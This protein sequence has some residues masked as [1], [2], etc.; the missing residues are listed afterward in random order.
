MR[1]IDSSETERTRE[2]VVKYHRK[3][4]YEYNTPFNS[5]KFHPFPG[6]K[7]FYHC[8]RHRP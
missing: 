7:V 4:L 5:I 8:E 2:R 1:A 3:K 6:W